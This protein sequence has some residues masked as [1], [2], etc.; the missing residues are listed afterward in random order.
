MNNESP[1]KNLLH[2]ILP[3]F[4]NSF[5]LYEFKKSVSK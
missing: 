3:G 4:G 5:L 2:A 1:V